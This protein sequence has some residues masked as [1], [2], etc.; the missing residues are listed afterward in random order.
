MLKK[1]FISTPAAQAREIVD[2]LCLA[3]RIPQTT[4]DVGLGFDSPAQAGQY[5]RRIKEGLLEAKVD[6]EAFSFHRPK[7][8]SALEI[9][10]VGVAGDSGSF[11]EPEAAPQPIVTT[12]TLATSVA[13]GNRAFT[14]G[15]AAL[16]DVAIVEKAGGS[17]VV[18]TLLV[19][20]GRDKG[21]SF[22]ESI[23]RF[24]PQARLQHFADAF[25]A[26]PDDLVS[27][28]ASLAG[29]P[30]WFRRRTTTLPD[31]SPRTETFYYRIA[32]G[33]HALAAA[34]M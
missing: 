2:I 4:V 7:D 32:I 3:A 12:P 33:P 16:Q 20:E 10:F 21:Q 22:L 1:I 9:S 28:S 11:D 8:S 26:S 31:G 30:A 24:P 17:Y 6:P 19:V 23:R 34:A 18:A 14:E 27:K 15:K 25:G 13:N 5:Q 29:T